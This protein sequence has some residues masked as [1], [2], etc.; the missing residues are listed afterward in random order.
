MQKYIKIIIWVLVAI[1]VAYGVWAYIV[2]K[3]ENSLGDDFGVVDNSQNSKDAQSQKAFDDL[4]SKILGRSEDLILFSIFPETKVSGIK[5]YRGSVKGGYFFEANILVNVLDANKKV[6][7]KG[8][9]QATTEWM[10]VEPVEFEGNIDF[11]NLPKGPAF[12]QIHND[13]PSDMREKDK[14]ILIPI[15]II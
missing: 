11:T 12:I 2:Y 13:N 9:A 5:S 7:L 4:K 6:L 3:N 10:T 14:E 15:I 1:I 8:N